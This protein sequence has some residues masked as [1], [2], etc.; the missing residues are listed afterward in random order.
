MKKKK[1]IVLIISIVLIA[2]ITFSGGLCMSIEQLW[3]KIVLLALANLCN[4]A[5][6]VIAMKITDKKPEFDIKNIR[7]YVI[8]TAIALALSLSIAFIPAL[9][10]VSLIGSH[11]DFSWFGIVYNFLNYFLIIGPV[12]ELVFRVYIQDTVVSFFDKKKYIGVV[13]SS[14]IF[15]L[16]HWINGS[17]VQV[18][19][20]SG[21]GLVFGTCKYL[22]KD[23]KYPG[24]ALGHGLYDF[25]NEIVRMF[26]I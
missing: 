1:T 5:V 26:I 18:L 12:E 4:G 8:G 21:I 10:G 11:K 22:I 2:G 23:C 16:W 25:L 13:V 24:L 19:F 3:L 15:G 20:A 6:A 17:F 9:C 7:Q 14:L